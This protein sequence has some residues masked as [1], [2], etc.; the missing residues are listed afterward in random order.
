MIFSDAMV[1]FSIRDCMPMGG[2][3]ISS[4]HEYGV[5]AKA[6]SLIHV[7]ACKGHLHFGGQG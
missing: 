2:S 7:P 5:A 1:K 4:W 3:R 6:F